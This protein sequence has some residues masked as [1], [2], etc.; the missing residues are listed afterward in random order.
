VSRQR[1]HNKKHCFNVSGLS[2]DS[3]VRGVKFDMKGL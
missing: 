1:R 2:P 3:S